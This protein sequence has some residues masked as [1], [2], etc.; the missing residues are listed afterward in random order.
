MLDSHESPSWEPGIIRILVS[1][2]SQHAPNAIRANKLD[3]DISSTT[4]RDPNLD[5]DMLQ[6]L[7][8]VIV[9]HGLGDLHL[10]RNA[11][12]DDERTTRRLAEE[13]H[14]TVVYL[15]DGGL[16]ERLGFHRL[17]LL[18][19]L[20]KL[21]TIEAAVSVLVTEVSACRGTLPIRIFWIY[22]EGGLYTE[23]LDITPRQIRSEQKNG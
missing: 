1:L 21:V 18:C 9:E 13:V 3:L 15:N 14:G 16:N 2:S 11:T 22:T 19:R 12:T 8:V 4:V 23:V 17:P 10:A 20:D 6:L 5:G 7:E